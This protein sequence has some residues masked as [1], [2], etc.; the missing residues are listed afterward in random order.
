MPPK[1]KF[2][3][4]ENTDRPAPLAATT[5]KNYRSS[6]DKIATNIDVKSINDLIAKPKEVIQYVES[7]S[8]R[9]QKVQS[10]AAIM[11]ELG[12]GKKADGTLAE[13]NSKTLK[14]Y[15]AYQTTKTDN[16][17]KPVSQKIFSNFKEYK[18]SQEDSMES[19]DSD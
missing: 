17:G 16:E 7:L 9:N 1:V 10:Y 14:Y 5:V 2:D 8:T 3:W 11:Y 12:I 6:L 4:V 19:S 13:L 15:N 18:L